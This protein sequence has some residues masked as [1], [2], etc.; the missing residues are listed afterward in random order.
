MAQTQFYPPKRH[1]LIIWL[2]QKTLPWV[3]KLLLQVDLVVSTYSLAQLQ[4]LKGKP[5]LILCN[6]P[7]FHD[8]M[9]MFLLSGRLGVPFYYLAAYEQFDAPVQRWLYQRLG[10]YSIRRGLADRPSIAHTI[11]IM[12]ERDCRLVIFPEG[13]CSFQNDTVMPLRS[14][15]VQMAL[16]AMARRVKVGKTV[17]DFYV[18][19]VSLKYR[20]TGDMKAAIVQALNQLEQ[21]LDL[22]SH[23]SKD[24]YQRLRSIAE[25]LLSRYEQEYS[26]TPDPAA[27]WNQRIAALKFQALE[28]CEL[29]LGITPAPS[30][31]HR[32]RVYRIRHL[33]STR[34]NTILPDGTDGWDV[35]RKA[36]VRMLNFD[37]IYDGYVAANPT[38]ERFLDTLVRFEREVFEI[39]QPQ[40]KGHRQAIVQIGEPVNLKDYFEAYMGDRSGTVNSLLD[41][42]HGTMQKNLNE[43]AERAASQIPRGSPRL[44]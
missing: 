19:P 5:Y 30:E 6:H 41:Q 35:V 23:G 32:E 10:A 34:I 15:G 17:R 18:V 8:P 14:G 33:L 1:S 4:G 38:P 36:S 22:P 16:Q 9:V 25:K 29:R 37:A 13:G 2:A 26:I 39:D 42:L 7:T 21:A 24:Y 28:Q 40:P 11:E 44:K 43:L 31:P 3:A 20:Y 12:Q 27:N